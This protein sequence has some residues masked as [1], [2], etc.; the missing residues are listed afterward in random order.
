QRRLKIIIPHILKDYDRV[1]YI[2]ANVQLTR[3]LAYYLKLHKGEISV[4]VHPKRNCVYQ[5]GFACI[6]RKKANPDAIKGQLKHCLD[7]DIKPG[8]G[9]YETNVIIRD[10]SEVVDE[11]CQTWLE[12]LNNG[13]HR[14]Q[15][16]IIPAR[17]ITGIQINAI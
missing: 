2:D 13:T 8:S 17:D 10:K 3:P 15:L 1:V 9:M 16:S 7:L 6:E 4:K 11:F 12:E 14:D 5:E